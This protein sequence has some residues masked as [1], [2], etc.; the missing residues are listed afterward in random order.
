MVRGKLNE[1]VPV[2]MADPMQD[3]HDSI[4]SLQIK[5]IELIWEINLLFSCIELV[6]PGGFNIAGS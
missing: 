5:E 2:Q 6:I 4:R 3:L 1:A